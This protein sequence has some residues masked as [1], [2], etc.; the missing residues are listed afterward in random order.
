[1]T[2]HSLNNSR[3]YRDISARYVTE[4]LCETDEVTYLV[5]LRE[6]ADYSN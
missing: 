6:K 5:N 3:F 1:M 4:N 2:H